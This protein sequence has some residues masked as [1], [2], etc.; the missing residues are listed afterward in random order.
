VRQSTLA[1][2]AFTTLPQRAYSSRICCAKTDL[3]ILRNLV[4]ETVG[5]QSKLDVSGFHFILEHLLRQRFDLLGDIDSQLF[6]QSS[7]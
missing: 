5:T 1:P 4:I 7:A 2:D 6:D 3:E